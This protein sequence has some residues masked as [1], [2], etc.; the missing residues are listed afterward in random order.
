MK[1]IQECVIKQSNLVSPK[2]G[3]KFYTILEQLSNNE[4]KLVIKVRVCILIAV[5]ILHGG[6]YRTQSVPD[7][8][9]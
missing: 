1:T 2:K 5:N 4:L 6:G 8:V 7:P 3:I 9:W